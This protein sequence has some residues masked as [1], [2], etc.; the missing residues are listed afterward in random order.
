MTKFDKIDDPQ[1]F[2]S[3]AGG[4]GG[5]WLA[6]QLHLHDKY[7]TPE[8]REEIYLD[9]FPGNRHRIQH[10]WHSAML[11]EG[12]IQ[13]K[14]WTETEYVNTEQWWEDYWKFVPQD[15]TELYNKVLEL[16]EKKRRFRITVH[17]THS[18][19]YDKYFEDLFSDW[20]VITLGVDKHNERDMKQFQSNIIKKIWWQDL[21]EEENLIDELGDKYKKFVKELDKDPGCWQDIQKSMEKF[22][23]NINYTD[24]M[25]AIYA[26]FFSVEEAAEKTFNDLEG[27]WDEY[28]I[29]QHLQPI[30]IKHHK[31]VDFGKL[32]IDKDYDTYVDMCNFLECTPFT[33]ERWLE[34]LTPYA[35]EDLDEYITV[36]DVKERIA[37]RVQQL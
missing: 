34:I 6:Y 30:P 11:F 4:S 2:V 9:K 12:I 13:P 18:A 1:V 7:N 3:Y 29:D 36:E 19:W 16:R 10:S 21:S 22:T 5:E 33:Q 23:G 17:R 31:I 20:R 24:M 8:T 25:T 27:R 32:I 35:Q 15:R 26:Y 14:L 28:A 37:K